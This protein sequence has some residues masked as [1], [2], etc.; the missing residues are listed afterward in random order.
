MESHLHPRGLLRRR[1]PRRADGARGGLAV[2]PAQAAARPAPDAAARR[3]RRSASTTHAAPGV[4][5]CTVPASAPRPAGRS[6]LVPT[7]PGQRPRLGRP[8]SRSTCR[9]PGRDRGRRADRDPHRRWARATPP[10]G[11]LLMRVGAFSKATV[12]VRLRGLGDAGRERRDRRR[13]RRLAHRGLAAGLGRRRRSPLEPARHVGRDAAAST[14]RSPSAATWC[15]TPTR[16]VRRPGRLGRAARAL[17]RRRRPAHRAPALRRPHR[18]ADAEQR[19]LQGRAPG[20]GG[21]RGVDR[22]RADPQGRRGHRDLRGATAT[23][24]SPTAARP[25]RCPTSRSRPARSQGAGHASATGR[26]DDD[27]LF[28]LRS[29]GIDEIEARRLVVHGFFADLIRKIDVPALRGPADRDAWRRELATTGACR[30]GRLMSFETR[31]RARRPGRRRRT[32]VVH[33]AVRRSRWLADGEEFFAVNDLCS[34]A[35]V[36]LSRGRGRRL[37]DRVLAARL[38]VRPAHRQ[39]TVLPA[40]EPVATFPVEV[41]DGAVFVDTH[42]TLN[43]VTPG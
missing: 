16:R 41:D 28:Y 12:V 40:T 26:F 1:R 9:R 36:A 18:A 30:S 2:H 5:R 27:Q 31:L 6:G 33:R 10:P 4:S 14:S 25:T 23:S 19:G 21:A 7:R 15:A 42:R 35:T 43:G 8:P 29:R 39:A 3:Q 22:Q 11:H 34:H 13:R 20:R 37:H 32:A 17:L 38:E 24:C